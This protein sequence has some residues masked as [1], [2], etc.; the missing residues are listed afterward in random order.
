MEGHGKILLID[1]DKA[2]YGGMNMDYELLMKIPVKYHNIIKAIHKDN[3]G[4]WCVIDSHSGYKLIGY[5]SDYTIHEID[6]VEFKKA[7]K[8]IKEFDN[9]KKDTKNKK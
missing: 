9:K 3:E 5:K 8:F 4:Y 7:F 1:I 6:F 2:N